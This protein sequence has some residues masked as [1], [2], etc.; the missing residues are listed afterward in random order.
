MVRAPC[1]S[2]HN[3]SESVA[4]S[5]KRVAT[6]LDLHLVSAHPG[7]IYSLPSSSCHSSMSHSLLAKFQWPLILDTFIAHQVPFAA[8]LMPIHGSPNSGCH[9]SMIHLLLAKFR[10]P[11][12][13]DPF[14][15]HQVPGAARSGLIALVACQVTF[16]AHPGPIPSPPS[17]GCRSF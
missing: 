12:V 17:S 13:L 16:A 8:H 5:P 3:L 14:P 15:A 7:T 10:L 4:L 1:L 11:L 2:Y 6:H 9:S